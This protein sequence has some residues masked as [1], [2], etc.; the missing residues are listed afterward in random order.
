M[1]FLAAEFLDRIAAR[2]RMERE[3]IHVFAKFRIVGVQ[4]VLGVGG[5]DIAAPVTTCMKQQRSAAA[6]ADIADA[7][8]W[9]A[10][11]LAMALD[12]EQFAD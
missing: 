1:A 12:P 4:Y 7:E 10:V 9:R 11:G 2:D 6:D 8:E 5:R 3:R